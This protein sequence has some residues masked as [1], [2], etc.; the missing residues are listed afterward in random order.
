MN[1][2]M[3][4]ADAMVM[5]IMALRIWWAA[6]FERGRGWLLSLNDDEHDDE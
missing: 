5:M 2:E 6:M 1:E 4:H 3:R